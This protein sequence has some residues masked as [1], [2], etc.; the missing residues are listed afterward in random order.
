MNFMLNW[1]MYQLNFKTASVGETILYGM[2]QH[3]THL[4]PEKCLDEVQGIEHLMKCLDR[5]FQAYP[6]VF[7]GKLQDAL[8]EAIKPK[9][10]DEVKWRVSLTKQFPRLGICLF[11]ALSVTDL[12]K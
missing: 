5:R 8:N 1:W 7:T 2:V 6:V 4:V 11:I 3:S 9:K 10:I 12:C